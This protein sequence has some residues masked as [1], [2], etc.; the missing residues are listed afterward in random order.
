MLAQS[1][2]MHRL[3]VGCA[4]RLQATSQD[5]TNDRVGQS[6]MY[7]FMYTV[8]DH[9]GHRTRFGIDPRDVMWP[10]GQNLG[11]V[12]DPASPPLGNWELDRDSQ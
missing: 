5:A 3:P 9:F 7:A 2:L 6:F 10:R 11:T 4:N 12:D 8:C 1:H